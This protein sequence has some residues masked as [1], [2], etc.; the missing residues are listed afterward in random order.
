MKYEQVAVTYGA[1]RPDAGGVALH[2]WQWKMATSVNGR[3]W[4]D[5]ANMHPVYEL[6]AEDSTALTHATNGNA[7]V[8]TA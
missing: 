8:K 4:S 3:E 6:T 5:G 7:P 2:A 1:S